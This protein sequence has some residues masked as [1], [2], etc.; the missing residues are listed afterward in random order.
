[1]LEYQS[2]NVWNKFGA[3]LLAHTDIVNTSEYYVYAA[4]TAIM[5]VRFV[6]GIVKIAQSDEKC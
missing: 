2:S 6:V 4:V 1:M 5:L 3:K